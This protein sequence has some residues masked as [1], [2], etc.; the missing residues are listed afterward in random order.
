MRVGVRHSH[1]EESVIPM[2]L[3]SSH[4]LEENRGTDIVGSRELGNLIKHS[5]KGMW[6]G[7]VGNRDI[8]GGKQHF[9]HC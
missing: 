6:L 5:A 8:N 7:W 9:G 3:T 1:A 2:F 4:T